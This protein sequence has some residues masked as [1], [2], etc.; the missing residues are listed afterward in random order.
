[1]QVLRN[2]DQQGYEFVLSVNKSRTYKTAF[3][4]LLIL[5]LSVIIIMSFIAFGRDLITRK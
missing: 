4:G 2:L 5:I 3:G 1:M